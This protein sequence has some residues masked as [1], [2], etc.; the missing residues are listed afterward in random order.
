MSHIISTK[1]FALLPETL[2]KGN[3]YLE[4][5]SF[6][7]PTSLPIYGYCRNKKDKDSLDEIFHQ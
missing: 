4:A 3:K 5:L 6:F 1:A 2:I 7:E